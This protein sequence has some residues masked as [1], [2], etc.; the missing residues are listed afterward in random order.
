MSEVKDYKKREAFIY[1]GFKPEGAPD[2]YEVEYVLKSDYDDLKKERDTLKKDWED[3]AGKKN[4]ADLIE[5]NM[6]LSAKL[7]KAEKVILF[8]ADESNWKT[9]EHC[10]SDAISKIRVQAQDYDSFG[11]SEYGEASKLMFIGGKQAREY[12]RG[13]E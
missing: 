10:E 12:L 5:E 11:V 2:F 3:V 13:E 1:G 7:E 8:Y 6:D 9:M 4:L